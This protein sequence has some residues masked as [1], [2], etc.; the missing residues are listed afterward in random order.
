M[1]VGLGG[2]RAKMS[3]TFIAWSRKQSSA[4]LGHCT[5]SVYEVID[6]KLCHEKNEVIQLKRK[7]KAKFKCD[8]LQ[9]SSEETIA[10]LSPGDL[11][12][13][14]SHQHGKI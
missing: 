9:L 12:F 4:Y 3:N 11:T 10:R 8:T 1:S 6:E 2:V 14:Y 7:T 13:L 5:P